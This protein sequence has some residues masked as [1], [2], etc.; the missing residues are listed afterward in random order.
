MDDVV[1]LHKEVFGTALELQ[2]YEDGLIFQRVDERLV[3]Y[4]LF[5]VVDDFADL[6]YIV[7][8]PEFRRLGYGFELMELFLKDVGGRGVKGITLEVR[9]DNVAA[10]GLY[11]AFAFECIHVRKGYYK[12]GCDG[13]LMRLELD[14]GCLSE[15]AHLV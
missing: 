7:V 14:G 9:S 1:A 8:A 4:V 12:D 5:Q 15:I 6:H 2:V 3:G 13:L 10:V 11:E